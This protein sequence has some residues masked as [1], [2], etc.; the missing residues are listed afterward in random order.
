MNDQAS[1]CEPP[2]APACPM[3][4]FIDIVAGKW[5]IPILYR[6][7][8]LDEPV[9]FSDLQRAIG[10]ITQKELTK[11]LRAFE[12]RGLIARQVFA[13]V[14]PRVEY[15]ITPLGATLREPLAALAAWMQAHAAE[16]YAAPAG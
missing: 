4:Q 7:I 15:C 14:P 6:L 8:V 2:P 1:A 9:R 11:Q 13:Q 16:L 10:R 5:A 3:L 12:Q